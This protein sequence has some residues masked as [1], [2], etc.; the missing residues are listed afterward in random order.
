MHEIYFNLFYLARRD[1]MFFC[2][3]KYS[4]HILNLSILFINFFINPNFK[5]VQMTLDVHTIT[6]TYDD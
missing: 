3:Q 4:E 2:K 1:L 5:I 6:I